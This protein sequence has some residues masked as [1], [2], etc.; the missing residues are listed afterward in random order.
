MTDTIATNP[1][2]F[3]RAVAVLSKRP[4]FM[5]HL[6][7]LALGGDLSAARIGAK[8]GCSA[9]SALKVALMRAPRSERQAF[10]EDVGRISDAAGVDRVRLLSLIRQAQSLAVFETESEAHDGGMLLAA[11]DVVSGIDGEQS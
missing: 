8:L 3:E 9:E 11:R 5:A 2:L 6:L 10:R 4:A 7:S 1:A